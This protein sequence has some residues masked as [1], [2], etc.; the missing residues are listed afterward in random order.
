MQKKLSEDKT[1]WEMYDY[2]EDKFYNTILSALPK[3]GQYDGVVLY[4]FN[5]KSFPSAMSF[6]EKT[7]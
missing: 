2:C 4:V 7:G 1:W 6:L 5:D 3:S